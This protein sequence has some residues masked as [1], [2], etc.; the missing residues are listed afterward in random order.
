MKSFNLKEYLKNPKRK[1]VTRDGRDVKIICT[2]YN[3]PQPIIAE[4]EGLDY[5]ESFTSDG[6]YYINIIHNSD[7]D[8]FFAPEKHTGW[9]N[10][11]KGTYNRHTGCLSIFKSKEEA[12]EAGNICKDYIITIQ[13]EWEE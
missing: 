8:L 2:N 12:E 11:Y 1:V 7:I 6:K 4:I 9:I 3:S 13:I 5:S 10:I